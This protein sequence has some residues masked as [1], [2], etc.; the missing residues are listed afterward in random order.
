MD[1]VPILTT[2]EDLLKVSTLKNSLLSL[3]T[4][5]TATNLFGWSFKPNVFSNQTSAFDPKE[6]LYAN[7]ANNHQVA[8]FDCQLRTSNKIFSLNKVAPGKVQPEKI[9]VTHAYTTFCQVHY[10][11]KVNAT[12][13]QIKQQSLRWFCGSFDSSDI[14]AR[15]N[16]INTDLH[17]SANQ[18]KSAAD[19]GYLNLSYASVGSIPF[20]LK[21]KTITNAHAGKVGGKNHNEFDGR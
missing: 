12:M 14:D 9:K 18:C 2:L 17:L 15:Q 5:K 13:C 21:D 6:Q 10:R 20:N 1:Q 11:T 16:V 4:K 19:R 7:T 8:H 3:T